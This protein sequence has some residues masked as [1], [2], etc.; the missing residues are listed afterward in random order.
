V[1]LDHPG[2]TAVSNRGFALIEWLIA[3]ALVITV[4]GAIFAVVLP[5]RDVIARTQVRVDMAIAARGALHTVVDDLREAGNS[6]VIADP[7]APLAAVLPAVTLRESLTSAASVV[8]AT[9]VVVRRS[10]PGGAQA[11]LASDA[12]AGDTLLR[13]STTHCSGGGGSCGFASTDRAVIFDAHRAESVSVAAVAPQ[14]VTLAQPLPRSFVSGSVL[15]RLHT[16]TYGWRV[17]GGAGSL[18]RLTDGG[19]EQPLLDHVVG[20]AII[21]AGEDEGSEAHLHVRLRV[22]A[23]AAQYRGPAGSLF[24]MPGTAS[25]PRQWV[26]DLELRARVVLRN[27]RVLP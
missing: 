16:T 4:A 18:V 11:R 23:S 20:F 25:G 1:C 21:S 13:L 9:A 14:F 17:N 22:Q 12:N 10:P 5:A 27:G 7:S 2:A 26:P 24:V 3:S 15:A 6:P 19:A 8:P